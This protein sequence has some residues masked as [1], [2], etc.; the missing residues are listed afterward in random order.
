MKTYD[1]TKL[2]AELKSDNA[3]TTETFSLLLVFV[4]SP[5]C[6]VYTV[7]LKKTGPLRLI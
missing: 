1:I 3:Y 6:A 4:S 5:S 2:I 7:C